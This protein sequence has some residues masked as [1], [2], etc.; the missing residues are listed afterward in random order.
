MIGWGAKFLQM[1]PKIKD[2]GLKDLRPLMLVEVMR[3][4][5]VGL[6]MKKIATFWEKYDLIDKSQHAYL[7]GR[8]THTV[9][10]QLLNSLEAARDFKTNLY[11]SSFDMKQAFDSVC[12]RLLLWCLV[13]LKIP[14]G[15]AAYLISLDADGEVFVKCPKNL[16]ILERGVEALLKEGRRFKAEKGVGQGDL[17]SPL[18]W[19]AV[20]DPL[21]VTLR[22]QPSEFKVQDLN[23]NTHPAEDLG[24]ADDLQSLEASAVALQN[25]SNLVSAWCIYTG[26]QISSTKMRTFGSHW[27]IHKGGNP[28][29]ITYTKGWVPTEVEMKMDG[30]MKSLGVKFDMHVD[31]QVQKRECIAT[32]TEKGVKI[33]QAQARRRDKMLALSYMLLTNV[34]YRSQHCPWHLEEYEELE[35]AYIKQVK[36]AAKLISGF[37]TRLITMNKRDGG[38]GITS[39]IT[40][41][42]EW[43]RKSLLELTHRG[44]AMSLAMQGQLSRMLRES[45][46]GGIGP[47]R[48]YLWI[49]LSQ[50]ATGLSSLVLFLRQIGLRIRVG[51]AKRDGWELACNN[52]RDTDQRISMN[53]RGIILQSELE[54]GGEAP[55]RIGQCW[56]V[57][58][59]I[60]DILGFNEDDI[61]VMEW[62]CKGLPEQDKMVWV[63]D[64][65]ILVMKG[66]DGRP[67]GMGGRNKIS[68]QELIDRASHLIELSID[69]VIKG[70]DGRLTSVIAAK[71]SKRAKERTVVVPDYLKREWARSGNENYSYIYTD[72]SYKEHANWG[73]ILLDE[74]RVEAAGAIIFS[75]GKN[76][77]YKI[78]VI[79]DLKVKD[80]NQVELLCQ[81][82]ACEIAEADKRVVKLGS[83]CQSAMKV[84]NGAY[85]EGFSNSIAG[86]RKWEG[87][88]T[89]KIAA[90]PE[91]NKAW[92]T[93]E[94]DDMGI[95]VADAVAGGHAKPHKTISA[96]DWLI[97]ISARSIVAIEEEDGTPF[98]GRVT[99]RVSEV[100]TEQYLKERD[101]YREI[102]GE[103][104]PKWEGANM[105]MAHKLL[106]R[107]G[108]FEDR[109]TMLKLK[110]GRRW[111][112]SK[113]N[114]ALC[115]LCG[116]SF[117]SQRHPMMCCIGYEV[118]AAREEWKKAI[119]ARVDKESQLIRVE[120]EEFSRSVFKEQ[121][122]E[123]AAVGT[124]T[125]RWVSTLNKRREFNANEVKAMKRL[126]ATMAQGARGVMRV[127]TRA[128][129][130]KNRNKEDNK[131]NM[132]VEKIA[133]LRQIGITK[134][135][136]T[137]A[138]ESIKAGNKQNKKVKTTKPKLGCLPPK[139]VRDE[140]ERGGIGL[141]IWKK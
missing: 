16:N 14:K 52:E 35:T 125:Q 101:G 1:I 48:T 77:F 127:F 105:A 114:P 18:F 79:I 2:A 112:V 42:M 4:I 89:F 82:I 97:R 121:D 80:A 20:L 32:I 31:N 92:G 49:A 56:E 132:A 5:W 140:I 15:L 139:G 38:L 7:R 45:G 63:S 113:H 53:A 10:Q 124:F 110:S 11:K 64:K 72:G 37:S 109:V 67:T 8:G 76:F 27:G 91:R 12:R 55:I 9:L 62:E 107:N 51:W 29:L 74:P 21:L 126:M 30:T 138:V 78:H 118:S 103:W 136:D 40:A 25:K 66:S 26:I 83:D 81:L 90:H 104:D 73:E 19:V 41:A 3:K 61:E 69:K 58:G 108:G 17:P 115:S 98:I 99:Q 43:K 120:M 23:G 47:C 71:K 88:E 111:D 128:S 44:G 95:Y 129:Q 68:K 122:G 116:E 94:F 54:E 93:W 34:V 102:D 60:F 13:R 131:R 59:K 100:N 65:D 96:R 24:F 33:N 87:I 119:K 28:K 6:I 86:W 50:N 135:L 133:E 57:D 84:T 130:D 137:I 39:T 36:I 141:V 85:S 75:D 70:G 22:N 106:K 46:Q 123:L 117:D 134:F